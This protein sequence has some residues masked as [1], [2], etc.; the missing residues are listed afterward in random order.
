M[1]VLVY[2]IMGFGFGVVLF[3]LFFRRKLPPAQRYVV[4]RSGQLAAARVVRGDRALRHA[5]FN[6]GKTAQFCPV[7][8][9]TLAGLSPQQIAA[10]WED[11]MAEARALGI[12]PDA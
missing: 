7:T 1:Y 9:L 8:D 6:L 4:W 10:G 11:L 5:L 2:T 3:E 12:L